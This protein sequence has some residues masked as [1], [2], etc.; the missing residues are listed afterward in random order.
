MKKRK[1]VNKIITENNRKKS[2]IFEAFLFSFYIN[3][4]SNTRF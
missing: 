4:G 1:C 3:Y 2:I